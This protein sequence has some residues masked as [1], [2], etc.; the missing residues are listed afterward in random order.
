MT[1]ARQYSTLF[2]CL[3]DEPEPVGR[4]GR[5]AHYSV[6]RAV[7]WLDVERPPLDHPQIHD[8]AVIW[9]EDHDVR[10]IDAIEQIY[11]AGLLSPVQF[12]GE[13]KGTLTAL[14]AAKFYFAAG[15]PDIDAY[16]RAID[17]IA[18][19]L[20]DPWP[21]EVG[22]FDRSP[23]NPHQNFFEGLISDTDHRVGLYLGNIDA[24]WRLGTRAYAPVAAAPPPPLSTVPRASLFP[25]PPAF[26]P[27]HLPSRL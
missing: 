26:P 4:I 27:Q 23:G 15:E 5:G 25:K 24:L 12:I 9:D 21:A 11:M 8:F 19:G 17:A 13:R 20:E 3:Y 2:T 14:V 1:A 18:Q 16:R 10:I 6:F 7:E 22:S